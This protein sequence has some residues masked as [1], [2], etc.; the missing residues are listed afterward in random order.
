MERGSTIEEG[1]QP[2]RGSWEEA[3]LSWY[4]QVETSFRSAKRAK[5]Q[6]ES[7]AARES[8]RM[9]GAQQHGVEPLR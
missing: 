9:R 3:V 5:A 4:E 2:L 6:E 8:R 7:G 1:W